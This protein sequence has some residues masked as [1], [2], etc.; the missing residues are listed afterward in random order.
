MD[1]LL[2]KCLS[3]GTDLFRRD[4]DVS[5]SE[6]NEVN[7]QQRKSSYQLND[8]AISENVMGSE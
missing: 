8:D 5:N 7:T 2:L 3:M 4:V 1:L 6:P